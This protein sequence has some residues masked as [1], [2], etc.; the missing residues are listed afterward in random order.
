MSSNKKK[1]VTEC[2]IDF[3]AILY[4][5]K[6]FSGHHNLFRELI[7]LLSYCVLFSHTSF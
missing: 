3:I 4:Y 2:A 1:I 5:Y 7:T 6:D